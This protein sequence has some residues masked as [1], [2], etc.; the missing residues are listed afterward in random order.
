MGWALVSASVFNI[1][2]VLY[3]IV[4]WPDLPFLPA[5]DDKAPVEALLKLVH[6]YGAYALIAL[7]ALPF[8]AGAAWAAEPIKVVAAENFYGDIASQIGVP[9]AAFGSTRPT[10]PPRIGQNHVERILQP[11][12][13][14]QETSATAHQSVERHE[15]RLVSA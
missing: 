2:T 1:P 12:R 15:R 9:V 4:P 3:G 14:G 11:T 8:L 5:L 6:A 7:V 13:Q 10:M